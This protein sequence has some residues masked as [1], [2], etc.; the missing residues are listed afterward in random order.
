MTVL[1]PVPAAELGVV[2]PHEHLL[3]DTRCYWQPP[4]DPAERELAE[5]PVEMGRL[6]LLRRNLFLVRDNLV[7]SEVEV[8]V[9]EALVFRRLGGGTIVDVTNPD[10]GRDPLGLQEIARRTGLHVVMGCG[11]Y[12]HLAHPGSLEQEPVEAVAER[13]LAEIEQG[14]GE[15]GVRPGVIGEIGTWDPLHPNEEKALRAAARAQKQSGLALSVHVHIAARKAH[16]V[17]AI[18]DKEG[19]DPGRVILGHLDIALGHLDTD[20]ADVLD[21]H[22]SLARR[23]CYLEYDTCG[24]E[25]FAPGSAETPPFWTPLDLTRA[26]AIAQL[27]DDGYG[28]RLLLSHD[29]FTKTQLR[30]YGGFGYAHILHDFQHRLR[31]VGLGDGDLQQLLRDNPRRALAGR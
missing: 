7:L 10:I 21:Y 29:V 20:Y 9:E 5:G 16:D 26:R 18:L 2:L 19:I 30:R 12:V 6:G 27:L 25:F 13:L 17:L 28:D 11:H 14:V 4:G 15:T 8:A 1:G 23:G 31:E 24:A 22:R 3:V